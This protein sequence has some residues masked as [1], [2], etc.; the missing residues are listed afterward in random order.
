LAAK[1]K[2]DIYVL[3]LSRLLEPQKVA[4]NKPQVEL[5]DFEFNDDA[6]L[7]SHI[8]HAATDLNIQLQ[9]RT[10][11]GGVRL[12]EQLKA[13]RELACDLAICSGGQGDAGSANYALMAQSPVPVLIVPQT[14]SE[15]VD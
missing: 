5:R 9:T 6:N 14:Y 11:Y 1:L 12:Q 2:A 3:Y 4:L 10:V 8:T 13:L 15:Q 7:L